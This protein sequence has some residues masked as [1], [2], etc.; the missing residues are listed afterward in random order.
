MG[1]TPIINEND[2]VAVD[3]IKFGDNDTLAAMIANMVEADL[4]I[5]LTSTDGFYDCNPAKGKKAKL[6][7]VVHEFTDELEAAATCETTEVGMGGMKSKVLA[8]K[9]VTSMGIPC[10]IAPG[11]KRV[12]YPRSLPAKK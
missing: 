4:F 10:V 5:N 8:A 2:T 11:K 3:E 12:F 9:N 7:S 1:V 6:I